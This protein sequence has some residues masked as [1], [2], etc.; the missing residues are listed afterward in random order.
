VKQELAGDCNGRW[1][2]YTL[3]RTIS[4]VAA[5]VEGVVARVRLALARSMTR[6]LSAAQAPPPPH[7]HTPHTH[8]AG[9]L[10]RRAR[11]S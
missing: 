7:T 5:N 8:E 3:Q 2:A 9:P 10:L 11:S 1:Y 6:R 4:N